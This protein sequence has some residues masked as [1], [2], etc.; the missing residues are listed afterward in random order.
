MLNTELY[1]YI[2]NN[3]DNIQLTPI[4]LELELY[5]DAL[6]LKHKFNDKRTIPQ[7]VKVIKEEYKIA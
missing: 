2:L 3:I 5:S 7:L 6:F 1:S 4:L